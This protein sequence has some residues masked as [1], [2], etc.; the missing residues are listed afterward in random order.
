MTID[1]SGPMVTSLAVSPDGKSVYIA[2]RPSG[3]PASQIFQYDVGAD[4]TLRPKNPATLP[5]R[6]IPGARVVIFSI[7]VSPDGKSVYTADYVIACLPLL[8][9]PQPSP[10]PRFGGEV[11]QYDVGP[12][13]KLTPKDPPSVALPPLLPPGNI[14]ISPNGKN[15]YVTN[16]LNYPDGTGVGQFVV[17]PHGKLAPLDPPTVATPT[18]PNEVAVSRD[19]RSVYV[20][21]PVGVSQ[22]DVGP[23][24]ALSPKNPSIVAVDPSA[25][26]LATSPNGENVYV[27]SLRG[28]SLYDV[29]PTGQLILKAPP[30]A[31]TCCASGV[32]MDSSGGSL[33]AI[34]P[35][36]RAVSQYNVAPD[37]S[38]SLKNPAF[39]QAGRAPGHIV[40]TPRPSV[41]G[42]K[43]Q[44]KH[45]GWRDFPQFKNQGGCVA[46]VSRGK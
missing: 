12:D 29:D 27:T 18:F 6:T 39:V 15:V 16:Y 38:L 8:T 28:L 10:P 7:V 13:G 26:S 4:G 34:N 14:A 21:S 40:V 20:T 19:S 3:R 9:C 31:E 42:S 17:G 25:G 2:G 46:F 24:G 11:A 23:D 30:S 35:Q 32:A 5:T 37:G 45:G 33:Y 44:C 36:R 43:E 1:D 41:P 22:Y